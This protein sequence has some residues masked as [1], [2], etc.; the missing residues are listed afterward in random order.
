VEGQTSF[1][2]FLKYQ[3]I[4]IRMASAYRWEISYAARKTLT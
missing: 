4:R 3:I 2:A 1:I